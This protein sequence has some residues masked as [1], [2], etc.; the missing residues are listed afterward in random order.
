MVPVLGYGDAIG[1]DTLA[2]R[3]V[4]RHMGI[5]TDIYYTDRVDK[6]FPEGTARPVSEMPVLQAEDIL[7][8]HACTGAPINFE[9]PK[10]GGRKV[11]IYHN[12][13]PPAFFHGINPDIEKIQQ[14]ALD[15]FRFL[16]D[17]IDYCIADSEYNRKDLLGMGYRCPI[18]VCPIVIPFS[19]YDAEPDAATMERMRADKHS[20]LLFVGRITPN[21]RQEDIIRA[22]ACYRRR[23]EPGSRLILIGS[24]GGTENYLEALK[25]YVRKLGLEDSV[26]FPG[27]IRFSEILA[28]YRTADAFVCMSEHEGFCVP[29][30]EA[31]YF[32]VPIVAFNAAAVP[33]TL[34]GGGLLLDSKEPAYVAAAVDRVMNDRALRRYLKSEQAKV[35]KRFSHEETEKTMSECIRRAMSL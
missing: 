32:G 35:L 7:I 4:I 15:G 16:A 26:I 33:D 30:V 3:D 8:Y 21:K 1:N 19:D 10:Y 17:K 34:G 12:V 14:D 5:T 24:A 22:F 13:T 18:D 31:M 25:T 23:Y 6:R 20:N 11:M 2:I 28:Y 29:L 9:L 27:H